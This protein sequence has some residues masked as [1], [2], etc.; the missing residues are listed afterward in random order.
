[1]HDNITL[2][3]MTKS[4]CLFAC[5]SS[6]SRL[7]SSP[8]SGQT[9]ASSLVKVCAIE[10]ERVLFTLH[11]VI[12]WWRSLRESL[13]RCWVESSFA[14]KPVKWPVRPHIVTL[15]WQEIKVRP[16][17][18][19]IGRQALGKSSQDLRRRGSRFASAGTPEP[20]R[21]RSSTEGGVGPTGPA[22]PHTSMV[23]QPV[24]SMQANPPNSNLGSIS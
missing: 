1:M 10:L 3:A 6:P 19:S 8:A 7:G 14:P 5:C 20:F 17:P 11:F 22:K 12:A 21:F 24:G 18:A 13:T 9:P 15:I 16:A 2:K 23:P 4:N